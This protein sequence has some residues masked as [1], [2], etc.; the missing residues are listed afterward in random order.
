MMARRSPFPTTGTPLVAIR[1]E[2]ASDEPPSLSERQEPMQSTLAPNDVEAM[3]GL[4]AG[5]G[6]MYG[7]SSPAGS[8]AEHS[9]QTPKVRVAHIPA[10]RNSLARIQHTTMQL[11]ATQMTG[12]QL[13][14]SPRQHSLAPSAASPGNAG[15]ADSATPTLMGD[16]EEMGIHGTA[17]SSTYQDSMLPSTSSMD[18]L[19]LSD[20]SQA[21]SQL[22]R[23]G[24][25][26]G[27]ASAEVPAASPAPVHL[28]AQ[29]SPAE[30]I[31]H[32]QTAF[33]AVRS[34]FVVS[35]GCW[36][37]QHVPCDAAG[38]ASLIGFVRYRPWS[39]R[40]Q[41]VTVTAVLQAQPSG[42]AL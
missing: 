17:P 39:W 38:Y 1:E 23:V 37:V 21:M 3:D 19:L 30:R 35:V 12:S 20:G 40:V 27:P 22:E 9:P 42:Y 24:H 7:I 36:H 18:S 2:L 31:S 6:N 15:T 5:N 4:A 16:D 41:E 34:P 11:N 8:T 25:H 33:D 29:T 13:E 28:T 26:H 32:L 10:D 14:A